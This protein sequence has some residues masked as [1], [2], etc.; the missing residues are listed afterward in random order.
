MSKAVPPF[1]ICQ[2][3]FS[4]YL[5]DLILAWRE[6]VGEV[7]H[8]RPVDEHQVNISW[9]RER[10]REV[11]RE[12]EREI[13]REISREG[14]REIEREILGKNTGEREKKGAVFKGRL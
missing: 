2:T 13:E 9:I 3:R 10:E 5:T 6:A 1:A 12:V 7:E 14:E 4:R 8:A 11:E